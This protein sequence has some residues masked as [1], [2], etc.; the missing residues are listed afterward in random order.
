MPVSFFPEIETPRLHVRPVRH[1]DLPSLLTVNG[2]DAVT[3]YLPYS[4]WRDMTDAEAWFGRIMA[5]QENGDTFQFVMTLRDDSEAIG[6]CLLFRLAEQSARAEIG[7]ALGRAHWGK[8]YVIEAMSAL[9]E[10]AFTDLSLHRLEAE[11]NPR[12]AASAKVLERMGF[13]KEGLLRQRWR[14]K[15]ETTDSALYGLLR[16]DWTGP[17]G[18]R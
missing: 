11:I 17:A 1:S 18:S 5:L 13:L 8:G 12:N 15:G 10:R 9:V 3:R 14:L 6:T 2:D 7:Y 16:P 4:T